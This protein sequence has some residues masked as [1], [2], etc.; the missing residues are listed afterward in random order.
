MEKI[1]SFI[2]GM[3]S[4]VSPTAQPESTYVEALNI[5]IIDDE[6]QGSVAIS[7]SKGNKFQISIPDVAEIH[8]ITIIDAGSTLITINGITN[9]T[10]FDSTNKTPKDLY[11]YI[12]AYAPY[13]HSTV[14]TIY[15]NSNYIVIYPVPTNTTSMLITTDVGTFLA[16][17]LFI[18]DNQN[19]KVIGYGIIRD[20]IY[21]FTT[22]ETGEDPQDPLLSQ[23]YG[24]IWKLTY[25]NITFDSSSATL[26]L[27]YANNLSFTT[28]YN[29]P[30][31]GVIGR[32]ENSN[33][34][35]LYW[36]DNYN[37]LR[38]LNVADPQLGALDLSL[39][40]V[41]PS[42]DFDIPLM[43]D[44][45]SASGTT[46]I[47][48][49][50]YQLAY[51]LSNTGGSSSIY[52]VP[53]NPIY[54]VSGD[55]TTGVNA[56][57]ENQ[58]GGL[59][60][61]DYRGA[62]YGTTTTKRITWSINNLD[63]QFSR[64]E[65]VVLVRERKNDPP[66]IYSI[67]EGPIQS[68][69]ID[70]VV[71]GDIINAD[72]TTIVTLDEFLTLSNVFTHCK[73]IGT[74]DNRL[75]V[76]N[77]RSEYS[78][79][80]FDAR[81]YRHKPAG[82]FDIIENGSIVNYP[83]A[84]YTDVDEESDAI[85][86]AN[87]EFTA[88]GLWDST[89]IYKADGTT[90]GGEGTYVSYEFVSVAIACDKGIEPANP[91]ILPLISTNPDYSGSSA[92]NLGV[93][94][95]DEDG[96][97]VLQQYPI[98]F[99][100]NINDGMKF[101]Q[102]NNLYWGYQHNEIY[103]VG[104]QFFDK[105]KNPYFVKWIGDIKF[106]DYF[107]TCLAA[108]NIYA[109]GSVTGLT[110][111]RKSFTDAEAGINA[112]PSNSSF[113]CQLGLKL[114]IDIPVA[115]TD[116][117]SGYSI[118]RVKRESSDKTIVAEGIISNTFTLN[119]GLTFSLPNGI[120]D[121][122][123]VGTN[124]EY[125]SF[126]TPNILDSSL[127][128]PSSGMTMRTNTEVVPANTTQDINITGGTDGLMQNKI[129][130]YYQHAVLASSQDHAIST[131]G[132]MGLNATIVFSGNTVENFGAS[133]T[134]EVSNGNPSYAFELATPID[135]SVLTGTDS[136]FLVYIINPI[137]NQY[138]G[139]TYTDRAN[140]EY[141]MCSHFRST[142]TDIVYSDSSYIFGGDVTNDIMDEER[143]SVDW[144]SYVGP[145]FIHNSTTFFYPASSPVNRTLRHGRHANTNLDDVS[146]PNDDRTDYFYNTVYS[147]E[148]NIL[149][150]FPK[151]DPF[152]FNEEFDSRFY[153]S[154]VKINGELTD[155]W[156]MF[157][158]RNYWDVE[159]IYGPINSM[160]PLADKMYFWQD[161]AFGVIEINPRTLIT[162]Q[163]SI[164]NSQVQTGTGR[165]LQRHDYI[166]TV[167]GSKHQGSTI[168]SSNALYWFDTNLI[169]I[170][171]FSPSQ[172][173][174]PLSDIKGLFSYLSK[175]LKT[176]IQNIDKPVYLSFDKGLNGVV[177]TYDNKKHRAIY[178]FHTGIQTGEE[179][180][181]Q[182]S[183]TVCLNELKDSFTTFYTFTPT[184]YINDNKYI[185][186]PDNN[187]PNIQ[188]SKLYLH[189][190]GNYGEFYDEIYDSYIKFIVNPNPRYTKVFDNL[191]LDTQASVYDPITKRY[192]NYHDDTW[193]RIRVTNDHQNTDIQTL[194][195]NSNLERKERSWQLQI[196]RN[197]V[198]YTTSNSPN[199]YVDLSTTD[200]D[201]GE[202]I[203]D[204]YA[205]IELWYSN[206]TNRELKTNNLTTVF[207]QS[208]R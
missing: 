199:I 142:K 168:A 47:L 17:Q 102:M 112:H 60:W 174:Q 117:I 65:A 35:R 70:I 202:R 190:V 75:V 105:A 179:S 26:E 85:C 111:Y 7:N 44:I 159:G 161:R 207:R 158:V 166:S 29:I 58:V 79:L 43:T 77:V 165:P 187:T 160:L 92:Y 36:T 53:S 54:L 94:S 48:I 189:D 176:E 197:R 8:K 21:L 183:F 31:T 120:M 196:P 146:T 34:Q 154:D 104:I 201:F 132:L 22:N 50:A 18:Q 13:G 185:I 171:R 188:L 46:P 116:K 178:T 71:D 163:G 45:R 28:Y 80:D 97:D 151:P 56:A 121:Y 96:T 200:K 145:G 129:L 67:Y 51:R 162:D 108:N 87:V 64:I 81:A 164:N 203:R 93:Y 15:Y 41:Q 153:I 184:I 208:I 150:F 167:T 19:L 98:G 130:K 106:P 27:I 20:N 82:D 39:V 42:S 16:L 118:V 49:G 198:L 182:K 23:G 78:D 180:F 173:N 113:V 72:D 66:I 40:D 86:P 141:I 170:Q 155:S 206:L 157:K 172:G 33:T 95:A 2:G 91:A 152:I 175:N 101:P 63:E 11:D 5:E 57:E 6:L 32:F 52:S 100:A 88:A 205:Q 114:D 192:I 55:L 10:P 9:P 1:Q 83:T 73:T 127:T 140:N 30:Q 148:N 126:L 138:G 137:V 62:P 3:N 119:A 89:A 25:D 99:P 193:D 177:A 124:K 69:S 123:A 109:D 186:S 68:N 76:G 107:D 122:D 61:A 143:I 139:N 59:L 191:T 204:K 156:S 4:D 37:K 194:T 147:A 144:A 181:I 115:L 169:K 133:G 128:I 12:I 135:T 38:S 84:D 110:D 195:P 74:K 103:R 125:V 134:P 90:I 24:Y 14:F 136:K 149:T 131:A